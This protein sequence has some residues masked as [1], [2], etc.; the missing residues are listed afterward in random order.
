[1]LKSWQLLA[2]PVNNDIP[3]TVNAAWQEGLGPGI[4]GTA[5]LGTII[6]NPT[7]GT[8]GFD[9]VAGE[10]PSMKTYVPNATNGTWV[11]ISGTNITHY[12]KKGY[13]IFIRGDRFVN[14]YNGTAT[15]TTLRTRGK[16]FEPTSNIPPSTT[17]IANQF[18]TIGNPYASAIDFSNTIGVTRSGNVQNIFYVWDPRLGGVY[19]GYQTFTKNVSDADYTVSPGGGSYPV[20]GTVHNYIES[21]QAFFVKAGAGGGTVGFN[22]AA[23]I[24]ASRLVT[25]L[26]SVIAESKQIRNQL[27][28]ID[29]GN[30]TLIDGAL[31]E[32]DTDYSD[33]IDMLD[34]LKLT[35]TGENLGIAVGDQLLSVERR[36]N[37]RQRDTIFYNLAQFRVKEYQFEFTPQN[38]ARPGMKA[39]LVDKFLHTHTAIS[40]TD[41]TK[42]NFDIVNIPGSYAKNRF[43]LVFRRKHNYPV[44]MI[45]Q[46]TRSG[47]DIKVNWKTDN[48]NSSDMLLERS[49]DGISYF[50]VY[51]HKSLDQTSTYDWM[52]KDPLP[53]IN[54]YRLSVMGDNNKNVYSNVVKIMP[55]ENGKADISVVNPVT[56]GILQFT[57]QQ[58]PK[59]Q[60]GVKIY[61]VKGQHVLNNSV[62]H[63]GGTSYQSVMLP[64]LAKG[65][66][67]LNIIHPGGNQTS[68]NV[69][70]E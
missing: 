48:D 40:L 44:E 20:A 61:T 67:K 36:N 60:Y 2:V 4:P 23:K 8:G 47:K 31:N 45:L 66:Y 69:F 3:Q 10:G 35:N 13:I 9:I 7:A 52:D 70:V 56:K 55:E 34:G 5:G 28:I 38:I 14:T 24:T 21:G 33:E 50:P 16:I 51:N 15:P 1:H 41:T 29:N 18:E 11:G 62:Y 68:M 32:F 58:L 63:Y 26:S 57:L 65:I 22:E 30:R 46:A 37:I 39:F 42:I 64:Y 59:G 43:M 54:F 6:T 25:R 49:A 27:Y 53:A 17:I 19:G 12:N